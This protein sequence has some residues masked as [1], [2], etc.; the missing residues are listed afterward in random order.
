MIEVEFAEALAELR[1]LA[2]LG[3]N[4]D[5]ETLEVFRRMRDQ[6]APGLDCEVDRS[7]AATTGR[8][9]YR[10]KLPQGLKVRLIALRVRAR[11]LDPNPI[12]CGSSDR[13]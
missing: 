10:Y 13:S 11:H 2:D 9:I 4:D 3:G 12:E 1:E 6:G 5:L 8:V 7:A